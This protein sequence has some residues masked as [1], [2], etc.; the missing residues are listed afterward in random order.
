[1][2]GKRIF[3]FIYRPFCLH[4]EVRTGGAD[5][6]GAEM[7]ISS[8]NVDMYSSRTYSA[9]SYEE[10]TIQKTSENVLVLS[11]MLENEQE[12]TGET[13]EKQEAAETSEKGTTYIKTGKISTAQQKEDTKT[14][15]QQCIQY[16]LE[17]LALQDDEAEYARRKIDRH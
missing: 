6:G 17:I 4:K 13:E 15:R 12:E 7:R 1:M 5:K 3:L 11:S 9:E 16:L 10:V 2:K 8:S 14:I